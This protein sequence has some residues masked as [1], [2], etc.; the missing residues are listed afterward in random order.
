MRV[1]LPRRGL[2][3][4]IKMRGQFPSR[5]RKEG[6]R[7]ASRW[8]TLDGNSKSQSASP[9]PPA[10]ED[11]SSSNLHSP[12]EFQPP[13]ASIKLAQRARWTVGPTGTK[14]QKYARTTRRISIISPLV[15]RAIHTRQRR[16][17]GELGCNQRMSP[18]AP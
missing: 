16:T 10:T 9:L 5:F 1:H 2:P 14:Q 12:S 4:T 15:V 18:P 8:L 7:P 17:P 3:T 13:Y 6:L 11:G